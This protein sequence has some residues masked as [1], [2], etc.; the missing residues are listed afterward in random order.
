M[1]FYLE[2]S[3]DLRYIMRITLSQ[4]IVLFILTGMSYAAPS[5]AQGV[6]N[7]KIN[8]EY[9][10]TSLQNALILLEKAAEVKFVYSKNVINISQHVTIQASNEKLAD[11]LDG[12][13]VKRGISY[14][15]INQQIVLSNLKGNSIGGG[16]SG[17][18]AA[19]IVI[20]G[21]VTSETGETLPGVSLKIKGTT[22]GTTTDAEGNYIL[23]VPDPQVNG[24]LVISYLGFSTQEIAIK[25]QTSINIKL[26]DDVK[27]L[28]EVVVIGYGTQT[29]GNNTGSIA[30]IT[31]KDIEERPI[32]RV[33]QAL[34]G[35]MAGVTV[36]STSG[37][38]GSDITVNVRGAASI[39]G[40]STPLYVVDGVPIDNLSGI[41]PS[42]IESIDVLK[43]AASA[44]IYGSRG[45]NGVVLVTTKRGKSGKPVISV[46]AYTAASSVERKVDVMTSDEWITFNKKWLDRQWVVASGLSANTSQA[47]RLAYATSKTG[48]TY[49]TRDQLLGI[50]G[51]YGIYDPYWG[52]DALDPIDW[53]DELF[54]SAPTNDIQINAS[55][56]TD[57]LN[58]SISGGIFK[59]EGVV[60]SSS[61]DRYSLRANLDAKINDRIKVGLS[62][63]PSLGKRDGANVDG[64]DNA[65]ARS[66]SFPGWVLSGSGRMAGADPYKFYDGWGPGANNVSP[67]VQAAYNDRLNRDVRINTA[68]N[69]TVNVIKGLD[70]NAL[71][72]W[73]YR[74]NDER[75]YSP[76]WIQGTWN[77]ATPGALSSS[78]RTTL[79]VNTLLTQGTLN[80]N[81]QFGVHS[82]NA[83]FGLSQETYREESSDQ[84][85]SGFPNDK[86]WVFDRTRATTVNYNT[87]GAAKNALISYF[88]RLQYS[89][90]DRYLFA[91]SV[92]Y[93]GSSKF[94]PQNRWGWF[95]SASVA[96]KADE[97]PFLENVEWLG[98]AKLRLSW[99]QAGNDRIGNSQF[100]SNMAALN[101]P[102][103]D[104]QSINSGF[105]VSNISNSLLRWEKTNSYNAGVDFGILRDRISMSADVYYKKTTDLLLSAPVSLI[106]GFST[107]L[108]NI[109]N[110][111][112]RGF[113][114]QLNSV[115]TTGKFKWS[116]SFNLSLN[117]NKITSLSA[118]NADITLGQGGTI[119]QRVGHP[120]NSYYLLEAA[121]VLRESDFD[122]DAAGAW[123]AK[124]PV[125]SG[126]KPGDT[127]YRDMN[128]DGKITSLDY[129]VAGSYQPDFEWGF[130][131]NFTFKR[132]DLS[133]LL[134]GRVG[135]DLLSIGSRGWN[136]ATNDT[137]WLYMEQWLTKAYWSEEEPGDGKTPAFFSAVTTQYDTN[138]LYKAGYLRIKNVALGYTLPV[139]KSFFSRARLYASCD[140]VFLWDS[141]YPGFS[142]EAATQD[143]ASSDWGSYPLARTLS[144]GLTATF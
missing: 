79:N 13:L 45:S 21:T 69:T 77:T 1:N 133:V 7:N 80:F 136:R 120:I 2:L 139:K 47:E 6:L 109:G 76:T 87:I 122:K 8:L 94:G 140:N 3:I 78:R 126:Q 138:W 68:L 116:S 38:P 131:N 92:R 34:Q 134:Q 105:V 127:K 46:S 31:S 9:N 72:A 99:G 67:Y 83:L 52:T 88:S 110:V 142:P 113:E 82:V 16:Y 101:Y 102:L 114:L 112:N 23:R 62:L 130:T 106:T 20:K 27:A 119:I 71:V 35:Q 39:N 86:T 143:N 90:K 89:L 111:E 42:D 74:G 85:L 141:Y 128:N 28:E 104:S 123:V 57:A 48:I 50:R 41:N 59:Q 30:K 100:L 10:T 118:D 32:T 137:K 84:G 43:D 17:M 63:A 96:W 22:L 91:A 95:P 58:Y 54:R 132:F 51:T 117:R 66:L 121:G 125:W 24:I 5:K 135:G 75:S 53:Q 108:D 49:T 103:G 97:E 129:T 107:M 11:I 81:R 64:K 25:G 18:T 144:F 93:D 56:S 12:L 124:I 60:E 19:D 14:E 55:G 15:V 61:F 70:A 33:E 29:K 4:L 73:N 36:R 115:N 98:T 44:A 26:R 40:V 37:A 65:V